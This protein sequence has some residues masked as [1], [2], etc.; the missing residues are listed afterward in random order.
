MG[1]R[2]AIGGSVM[3]WAMFCCETLYPAI[4]LDV[5]L[6]LTIYLS[7]VAEYVVKM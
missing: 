7:I 2:Q 5:T 3:V 6:T 4:H 1:R